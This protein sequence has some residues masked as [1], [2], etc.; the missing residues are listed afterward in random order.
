M[1]TFH[2]TL[3]LVITLSHSYTKANP[4]PGAIKYYLAGH[5]ANY[6]SDK[7]S[8]YT[9]T[10]LW[11]APGGLKHTVIHR[12][13][14]SI[15]NV[16]FR[17][18]Y[19]HILPAFLASIATLSS[20]GISTIIVGGNAPSEEVIGKWNFLPYATLFP[21][22]TQENLES[23]SYE[24][25]RQALLLW[26]LAFLCVA[27]YQEWKQATFK[28]DEDEI[29]FIDQLKMFIT[30]PLFRAQ[31]FLIATA[32][33]ATGFLVAGAAKGIGVASRKATA[34]LFEN[35]GPV[36]TFV[37]KEPTKK[38]YESVFGVPLAVFLKLFVL[39]WFNQLL[40]A[41]HLHQTESHALWEKSYDVGEKLQWSLTGLE[42]TFKTTYWLTTGHGYRMLDA[43]KQKET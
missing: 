9:A 15:Y 6:L 23:T 12:S 4:L 24:A 27:W 32:Y 3:L 42:Y 17:H 38:V 43:S 10:S 26:E 28:T 41:T 37:G 14:K 1:N 8:H 34:G 25:G 33:L 7:A 11:D 5:G 18:A 2:F 30:T 13:S 35:P 39:Y 40:S 36:D 21:G 20:R 16:I 29:D 19:V 31:Q 22:D